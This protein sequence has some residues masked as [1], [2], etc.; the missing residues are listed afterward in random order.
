MYRALPFLALLAVAAPAAAQNTI[1]PGEPV[2]GELSASDPV[3]DDGSHYDVWRFA[4]VAQHRYRVTLRSEDFDA[5]LAVGTHADS[6]CEDCQT[7]DD[8]AG[9]T[10]AQVEFTRA[11]D[12]TWEIRANS[13]DA[14]ETGGYQLVLED[15]GV[16][17]EG[18]DHGEE[19][20]PRGEPI[21][22]DQAV[23]G[24]LTRFDRKL[25]ASYSDT[26]TYDGRAG[27]TIIVTLRSEDFDAYL[28]MGEYAGGEC[29]EMD[30]NNNGAGGTDSKLTV[31]LPD[32]GAYHIHVSSATQ[33]GIGRYT[34]LVERGAEPL[35]VAPPM[36]ISPGETLE[37]R[38]WSTDTEEADG[39]YRD[40]W[41]FRGGVG[42]T[43][44][45][46]LH[47]EDFDAYLH[48]GQMT[49]GEWNVL[50][51]DDDG[52]GE[53]TDAQVSI[54]LP[55]NGEYLIRATSYEGGQ[56][57]AYTLRLERR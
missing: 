44:V 9:G 1:R 34:L 55:V 43:Y 54:T 23:T 15:L 33:G 40:T 2:T 7:D 49:G 6:D 46:T 48:V 37:G 26:W 24:E 39:S 17:E 36:P 38:L 41:I 3:L 11:E 21:A 47:S 53:G 10:D 18:H 14:D 50:E 8:G 31:E 20:A 42:E 45:V 29:T 12:G 57:G 28:T 35:E 30:T 22:L 32:D 13:Y 16:G 52:A 51:T 25:G 19:A 5:Y 27:E 56:T 4:A